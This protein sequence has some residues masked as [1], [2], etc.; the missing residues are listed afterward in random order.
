VKANLPDEHFVSVCKEKSTDND[1][2][3]ELDQGVALSRDAS[4]QQP[5]IA[6]KDVVGLGHIYKQSFDLLSHKDVVKMYKKTPKRLRLNPMKVSN[7][8]GKMEVRYPV[9][10][11]KFPRLTVFANDTSNCEID[12]VS[13][14][15]S[16]HFPSQA[17]RAV[18]SRRSKV[19]KTSGIMHV[20]RSTS[21]FVMSIANTL[22]EAASA[23]IGGVRQAASGGENSHIKEDLQDDGGSDVVGMECDVG[24]GEDLDGAFGGEEEDDEV[25]GSSGNEGTVDDTIM[26]ADPCTPIPTKR[27][28]VDS[29]PSAQ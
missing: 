19:T 13:A 15:A 17:A 11:Y 9:R 16:L 6:V 1:F 20:L 14:G 8:F 2:A 10:R 28:P 12:R 23:S 27:H 4:S 18:A 22:R 25:A 7:V 5:G 24:L 21:N 3:H 29:M 26:K